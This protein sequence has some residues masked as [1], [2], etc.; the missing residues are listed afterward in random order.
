MNKSYLTQDRYD[1][2]V[3]ELD[4]LK[5]AGRRSV[6]E[7]LKQAKDLGDLSENFDYQ[8]AREQQS[9]LERRILELEELIRHSVIIK[10]AAGTDSVRVGSV[11]T[12]KRDRTQLQ[13]SITGSNESNPSERKISNESPL[14]RA[15]LGKRVGDEVRV[16]TPK[17]EQAYV[18]LRIE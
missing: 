2:I 15:L 5:T 6:A 13:Y 1:E 4:E 12:L 7:H 9:R 14:G 11:V 18:I 3:R 16:A 17:G 10:Q 8:E